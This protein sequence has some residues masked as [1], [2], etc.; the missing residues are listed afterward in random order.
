MAKSELYAV[1]VVGGG[2]VGLA[3]AYEVA[4][5]GRKVIV[6]E[7]NN[8]FNQAGSSGDLARMF[9]TMYT[10]E[11]MAE[12]AIEAM[13]HWDA[14]EKDAG[15]SLRWMSG[16]L[17]FGDK[18]MGEG[19]PEGTLMGPKK[20]LDHFHMTYK[21]LSAKQIE[22]QY[23]FKNL[24]SNWEGLFAPD[25]GVI[26]VQLLLRT[27]YNL[28]KDY[29]AQAKQHTSVK[30]I[31]ISDEDSS[32]WEVHAMAHDV[33]VTY[34]TKKVIITGGAYVNHV[35]K[36]S[37]GIS[38]DLDIWEM[39]ATYF[40]S[41]AGPNGTI[42][43]SMWFQFAPSVDGRSRLFYG[44]PALPWGPPNVV[45][46]SVDAATRKI[47]DPSK[48]QASVLDPQ[49]IK[50]TQ[51]FVR[52]H[53]VGVDPTVP[54]STVS[55]LQT[56]VFDNMFVLDFLPEKYLRGGPQ[57]SIAIFTA[58]WAM[59]FVPTLGK[60]LS[61]MVLTGKSEYAKDEFHITRTDPKGKGIII[62]NPVSTTESEQVAKAK[63]YL[64]CEVGQ[65][66]GSS[67]RKTA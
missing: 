30:E 51:D 14:L 40:N 17:N 63:S 7:Q 35:L 67:C 64:Y 31:R 62:E 66:E 3:A 13:K 59:K 12:L 25:N 34:L 15:V 50:D 52:D 27:L 2:P 9:R 26:N 53:V 6:L 23:P 57:K 65:S 60:A 55:C 61:Q 10:E 33:E 11:F 1:V 29:G 32:I 56:N 37:F 16:L 44:F 28:A 19:T 20:N 8:F 39:V 46:I 24:E 48:R 18:D 45:R 41:N 5:T 47:D 21:E 43:P 38:L 4:K 36:P 42:F 22:E 54:A 58:G 49:D